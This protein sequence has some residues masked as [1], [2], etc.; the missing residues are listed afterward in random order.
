MSRS[1]HRLGL[2]GLAAL[3]SLVACSPEFT[4]SSELR[5]LR[6]MGVK[7]DDPYL[8]PSA[9]EPSEDTEDYQ[10]DNVLELTM[11]WEDAREP[12][13]RSGPIERRW[14][15]G[16]NNPV[17]DGYFACLLNVWLGFRAQKALGAGELADGE[18]FRLAEIGA[19]EKLRFLE[20]AVPGVPAE[21]LAA[22]LPELDGIAVGAGDRFSLT[23]PSD[24]ISGHAPPTDPDAAPYGIGYVFFTLCDGR[25]DLSEEWSGDVDVLEVLTDATRGFPLA[26]YDRDTGEV[27]DPDHYVA[28]Y[29]TYYGFEQY[30]NQ[31]PVIRGL[32]V[33]GREVPREH[34]CI[35]ESCAR[36]GSD[37]T[38]EPDVCDAPDAIRLA[39]CTEND[40]DD[41]PNID[42]MA[43]LE[44]SDNAE[45]DRAATDL[46][47]GGGSLYEQMWIRYYADAGRFESQVRRLQDAG[48]G[49]FADHESRFRLPKQ[50]GPLLLWAVAYDNRGGIDWVRGRV[51]VD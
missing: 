46:E 43:M 4:P 6:V 24:L 12:G 13:E 28:G 48:S 22:V 9:P 14:F 49:W 26:C 5:S 16:C 29:S 47:P 44:E 39:R 30:A 40:E 10:P 11:A 7:K 3:S 20:E 35:G 32:L 31:N 18:S 21:A 19:E 34:L 36:S 23:V 51:C 2:L 8:R 50:R 45:I 17:G 25:L 41:C 38:I 33:D 27:R 15:A 1:L 42:V 37:T